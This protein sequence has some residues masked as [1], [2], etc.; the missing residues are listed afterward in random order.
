[1]SRVDDG[2]S[3]GSSSR[4]SRSDPGDQGSALLEAEALLPSRWI[5]S[6]GGKARGVCPEG[7]AFDFP[8]HPVDNYGLA[9]ALRE[10]GV[11]AAWLPI[12]GP[13]WEVPLASGTA[14]AAGLQSS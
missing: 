11:Q 3:F 12:I 14:P 13:D 1:M 10:Q 5:L 2:A 9:N 4:D 6:Q 8:R 7:T